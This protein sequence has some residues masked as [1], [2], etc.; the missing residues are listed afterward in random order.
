M[1]AWLQ[2]GQD[3]KT[4]ISKVLR[5]DDMIM[6]TIYDDYDPYDHDDHDDDYMDDHDHTRRSYRAL[7]T[8]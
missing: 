3:I 2:S 8:G 4:V 7:P 1:A 5:D 6:S